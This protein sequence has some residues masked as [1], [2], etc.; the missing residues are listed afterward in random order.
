M[1][2]SSTCCNPGRWWSILPIAI[3]ISWKLPVRGDYE[4]SMGWRCSSFRGRFAGNLDRNAAASRHHD[5]GRHGRASCPGVSLHLAFSSL[6]AS[7]SRPCSGIFPNWVRAETE[8]SPHL[9]RMPWPHG[10]DYLAAVLWI[11]DCLA[12]AVPAA[13]CSQNPDSCGKSWSEAISGSSAWKWDDPRDL[14]AMVAAAIPAAPDPGHRPARYVLYINSIVLALVVAA[15]LGF[16]DGP[17]GMG[18]AMVGLIGG[19]AIAA[20]FFA[21]SRWVFR[22]MSLRISNIGIGDVYIAAAV[23]ALVREMASCPR[24]P[25]RSSSR[26]SAA[27]C[28]RSSPIRRAT[29]PPR[30]A[31]TSASVVS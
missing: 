27:C 29:A 25:L 9:H 2:I 7:R 22:S 21:L 14:L 16:L 11:P 15:I 30:M 28:F 18:S 12:R 31:P 23:G 13:H 24:L 4:H 8:H 26:C 20:A 3:P 5:V 17:R 6:S 10:D 19:V 1:P